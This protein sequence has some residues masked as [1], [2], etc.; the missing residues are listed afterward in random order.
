MIDPVYRAAFEH[1]RRCVPDR[2]TRETL[3]RRS[4]RVYVDAESHL[5]KDRDYGLAL[6]Q[7]RDEARTVTAG[8]IA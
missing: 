6:R 3:Q 7:V 2:R 5:A 1:G 8:A 4:F